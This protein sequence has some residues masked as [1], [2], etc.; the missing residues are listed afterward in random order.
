MKGD[1]MKCLEAG[2]DSYLTKPIRVNT[3]I[4]TMLEMLH[5]SHG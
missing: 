4:Q 5:S 2:C 1:R 3:L